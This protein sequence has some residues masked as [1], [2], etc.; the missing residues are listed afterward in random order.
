MK[1]DI[2]WIGGVPSHYMSEFHLRLENEF[3]NIHFLY[4]SFG[5][6]GIDFSHE[7][8]SLPKRSVILSSINSHTMIWKELCRLDPTALIVAGTYPRENLVAIL[9]ARFFNR[10]LCYLSDSNLFG[11]KNISRSSLSS[12]ILR[13]LISMFDKL[14]IIGT[15]NR[16]FYEKLCGEDFVKNRAHFFPL[17]HPHQKFELVNSFCSSKIKVL[18]LGR[19]I[20]IKSVDKV[21]LA[22]SSLDAEEKSRI[23]LEI[24]GDGACK[25]DLMRLSCELGI[26]ENVNF[27]GSIP[28]DQTPSIFSSANLVI[29]PSSDE[30]WGLV[31]NEALSSGKPVIVP[32]WVGACRDLIIEGKTGYILRDNKA[33]SIRDGI[34]RFLM[35]YDDGKPIGIQGRALI[36]DGGWNIDGSV[37]SFGE[38]LIAL[39]SDNSP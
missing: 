12:W 26:A 11:K 33:E 3:K 23:D 37:T 10:K 24:V 27:K 13:K 35:D 25:K 18:V 29:V 22:Y 17:P 4:T 9:W 36:R 7:V 5:N 20:D 14:L 21:I 6:R 34:R 39:E 28:S 8:V 19:L 30:P 31:V 38:L 2:A 15:F 32:Y 16:E 1:N